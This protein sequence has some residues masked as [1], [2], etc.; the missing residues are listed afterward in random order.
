MQPQGLTPPTLE[1]ENGTSEV[2][3]MRWTSGLDCAQSLMYVCALT[4]TWEDIQDLP[5]APERTAETQPLDTKV[6]TRLRT[7]C[8]PVS[9]LDLEEFGPFTRQTTT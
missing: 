4:C 8:Q 5:Q 2:Q 1:T 6:Q 9:I 7:G 3:G